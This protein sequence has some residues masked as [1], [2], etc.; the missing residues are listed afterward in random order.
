MA[1]T[2]TAQPSGSAGTPPS[3]VPDDLERACINTVKE[4]WFAATRDPRIKSEEVAGIGRNDYWI[5]GMP[6]GADSG[7][8]AATVGILSPYCRIVL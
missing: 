8:S 5:G 7:L 4:L 6:N 1:S 3:P 2:S